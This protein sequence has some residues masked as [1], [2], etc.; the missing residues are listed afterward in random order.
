MELVWV[1]SAS[2]EGDYKI[3]LLFNNGSRKIFDFKHLI[4][5]RPLFKC[6][7][8]VDKFKAFKV[9]DWTLEW[10]N[11]NIDIAPEYLYEHGVLA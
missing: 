6:L 7:E 10:D 9:G 3:S 4:M 8:D 5:T 2:Y 1:T 11:G